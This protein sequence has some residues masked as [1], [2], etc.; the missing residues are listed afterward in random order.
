MP[1]VSNAMAA[2]RRIVRNGPFHRNVRTS[3]SRETQDASPSVLGAPI[4]VTRN[5]YPDTASTPLDLKISILH[6]EVI[7]W[8]RTPIR[9]GYRLTGIGPP[10]T[11]GVAS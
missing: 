2:G 10:S 3:E 6:F 9:D 5:R 1:V 4:P 8:V 11:D 7:S